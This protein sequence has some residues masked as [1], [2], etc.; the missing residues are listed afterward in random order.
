[1]NLKISSQSVNPHINSIADLCDVAGVPIERLVISC[2]AASVTHP[3]DDTT[4]G[5]STTSTGDRS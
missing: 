4:E 1:M 2:G 5:E 3:V